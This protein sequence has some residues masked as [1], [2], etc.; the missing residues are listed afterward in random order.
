[1][2]KLGSNSDRKPNKNN[3]QRF[4]VKSKVLRSGSK[5]E[6]SLPIIIRLILFEIRVILSKGGDHPN[7]ENNKVLIILAKDH[8]AKF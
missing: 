2:Y 6:N 8:S 7:R 3:E 5:L 1:M 4:H